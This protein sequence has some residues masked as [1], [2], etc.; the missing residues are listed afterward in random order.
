MAGEQLTIYK[1]QERC[2]DYR[3][4]VIIQTPKQILADHTIIWSDPEIEHET[5][6][7]AITDV[8]TAPPR[9]LKEL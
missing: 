7:T 3:L 1:S 5:S 2:Y 4:I 9:Q 6:C 8:T